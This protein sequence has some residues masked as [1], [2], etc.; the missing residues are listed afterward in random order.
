MTKIY[1]IYINRYLFWNNELDTKWKKY[2]NKNSD[3]E[4]SLL[5][6]FDNENLISKEKLLF[7][8]SVLHGLIHINFL[9][10]CNNETFLKQYNLHI[11]WIEK[12]I[13]YDENY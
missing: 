8:N 9:E 4:V 13:Y 12:G 3:N 7:I 1:T 5:D 6:H 2:I 10:N 11:K